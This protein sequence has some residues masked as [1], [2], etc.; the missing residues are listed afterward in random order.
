MELASDSMIRDYKLPF[1]TL[2]N[3]PVSR[4]I[5]KINLKNYLWKL[6]II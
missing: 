1:E 2:P 4:L 5:E 6:F 3:L